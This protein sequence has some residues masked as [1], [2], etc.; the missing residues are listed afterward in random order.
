MELLSVMGLGKQNIQAVLFSRVC[1]RQDL[2]GHVHLSH[3]SSLLLPMLYSGITPHSPQGRHD[4]E[5]E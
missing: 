5:E 2:K 4:N 3:I 1:L